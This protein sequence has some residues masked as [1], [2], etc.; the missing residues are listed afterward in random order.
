MQNVDSLKI[1][2]LFFSK[3]FP[4]SSLLCFVVHNCS[5][6]VVRLFFFRSHILPKHVNYLF[7]L[8]YTSSVDRFIIFLGW[9]DILCWDPIVF[10][11]TV[12]R[13]ITV[14]TIILWWWYSLLL[15]VILWLE[16][17]PAILTWEASVP[18][19]WMA[20]GV[21]ASGSCVYIYRDIQ[22]QATEP[23]S[24]RTVITQRKIIYRW[25]YIE[26]GPIL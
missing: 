20:S 23:G 15:N 2:Q 19:W 24:Y 25:I 12:S 8:I 4:R 9:Y 14:V 11:I 6:D 21:L 3:T 18:P 22:Q 5:L 7:L 1:R 13:T 10:R 16:Y 17:G 26:E